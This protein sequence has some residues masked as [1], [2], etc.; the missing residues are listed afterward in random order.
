MVRPRPWLPR[1]TLKNGSL[2][3]ASTSVRFY[4]QKPYGPG[5][6]YLGFLAGSHA[7]GSSRG[8]SSRLLAP[9]IAGSELVPN[10][11]AKVV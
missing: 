2:G 3:H 9:H 6:R 11:Q 1:Y 8:S 7:I 5:R 4:A 10:C